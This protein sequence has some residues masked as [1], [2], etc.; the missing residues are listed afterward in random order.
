M[1]GWKRWEEVGGGGRGEGIPRSSSEI[2]LR[3]LEVASC[4]GGR[5]GCMGVMDAS[6]DLQLY[7]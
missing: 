6:I 1:G 3:H 4:V 7:T 2:Q 5:V